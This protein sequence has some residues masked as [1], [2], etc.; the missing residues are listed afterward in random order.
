MGLGAR[1][2]KRPAPVIA[3]IA[4]LPLDTLERFSTGLCE[5]L[6]ECRALEEELEASREELVERLHALVPGAPPE[7]RRFLLV[8]KRDCFNRRPLGRHARAPLWPALRELAGPVAAEVVARE[9]EAARRTGA[10]R[11][12]FALERDRQRTLLAERLGDTVFLRGLA[13]ANSEVSW[14][15]QRLRA[16]EGHG[17]GRRKAETTLLRY[18]SRAAVKLSPFST[19]TPVA[20]GA[21][22]GDT[23]PAVPRLRGSGWRARS[24]VRV[25][26]YLLDEFGE[27]LRR[28]PPLRDTLRIALN[29]SI[30]ETEPGRYL[31][32]RP[33]WWDF[34]QRAGRLGYHEQS[35]V[36]VG[37]RGPLIARL[38]HLLARRRPTYGELLA[39]LERDFAE[40]G[41]AHQ[42]AGQLDELLRIGFLHLVLPW[43]GHELHREKRMLRHLRRLPPDGALG[44]FTERLERLVSLEDGYAAAPDP[45]AALREMESV[46]GE[47]W[48]AAAPLGGLDPQSGY[49]RAS[50]HNVYEEVFLLPPRGEPGGPAILHL[51][52][53]VAAEA[54]RSVEPLVRLATLFD[55]R[56]ELAHAMAAFAAEQRPGQ[57]EVGLLEFFDGVRPLW[58][59]YMRFRMASREDGG[60]STTWNPLALAEVEALAR[61]RAGV[62]DGLDGC[63]RVV[64]GVQRVDARALGALLD[65]VPPRYTSAAGGACLFLQAASTDGSLWMLNRIKEGTG[66]FSSRYTPV[67]DR[68][69]RGRF[70]SHLAARGVFDLE[71]ERVCLL[72]L[73]CIQ[74]DNLNAHVPQTPA[75]LS[76]PGERAGVPPARRVTLG[77]LRIAFHGPDRAPTLRGRDGQRYMAAYLGGAY[78]DYVPTLVRFLCVFGPT[79]M[80]AVFPTTSKHQEGP[81]TVTRRTVLGNVVLH[82]AAWTFPAGPLRE[83]LAGLD[84]A[85]AFAAVTRWRAER[86]IPARVFMVEQSPHPVQG[87]RYQPQYLDFT[88]PLFVALFRSSLETQGDQVKLSEVLPTP[89]MASRDAAGR[90]WAVE[91]LLESLALRPDR[92]SAPPGELGTR[93]GAIS[94][95]VAAGSRF[96]RAR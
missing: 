14:I 42:V 37:L 74:G 67:M 25:K 79:E 51:S 45:E 28:Y 22:R 69:T 77:D 80:S 52:E 81:V 8:V 18:V 47:L 83:E 62:L 41:T 76:L 66:R 58:R 63:M 54:L 40:R 34:D 23:A 44:A 27:M 39:A 20:L 11:G 50:V 85:G 46:V 48:R 33:A 84:D 90:P 7:L 53:Q 15:A 49:G 12:D 59:E 88:S 24:L 78:E 6:E 92:L 1:T 75:V 5:R 29:S 3:R 61:C 10:F 89:E 72:D 70:A 19:L 82:R 35:L 87:V 57:A 93:A 73:R 21:I 60:W 17:H 30:T 32:L 91:V 2:G 64:D 96:T 31:F 68:G 55:H 86:G 13:L 4:G 16:G 36:K 95:P 71:G 94:P 38:L 9:E 56:H 43:S 65:R 26:P